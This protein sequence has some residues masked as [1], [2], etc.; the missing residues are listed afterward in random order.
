M[1]GYVS[2]GLAILNA[3]LGVCFDMDIG[4]AAVNDDVVHH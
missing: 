4:N 3:P 1:K 2:L